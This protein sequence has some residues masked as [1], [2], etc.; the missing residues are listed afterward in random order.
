MFPMCLPC[1]L[2]I[3]SAVCSDGNYRKAFDTW[4]VCICWVALE[5][6]PYAEHVK[7]WGSTS[8]SR[9]ISEA[10][11]WS[12]QGIHHVTQN[13]HTLGFCLTGPF[14][15][16]IRL[17]QVKLLQVGPV[18]KSKLLGNVVAELLHVGCDGCPSCHPT[19][20][21]ELCRMTSHIMNCLV[22]FCLVYG[23][24]SNKVFYVH[25]RICL[26]ASLCRLI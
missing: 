23:V 18:A 19:T 20:A 26:Q 9:C 25:I 7:F 13:T 5:Q 22:V 24:M 3:D 4:C 8:R 16:N 14:S 6:S 15:R 17:L 21:S 12:S 10:A 2:F 11:N 1:W